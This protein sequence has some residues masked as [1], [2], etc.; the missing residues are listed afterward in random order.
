MKSKLIIAT[1][2]LTSMSQVKAQDATS[3]ILDGMASVGGWAI[4]KAISP[5]SSTAPIIGATV[6][7]MLT[8]WGYGAFKSKDEEEKLKHYIAGRNYERW[9][10][11]QTTWYQSTLDP[12]TGRPPA[13]DGLKTMDDGIPT[14][15]TT[16]ADTESIKKTYTVPVK[17]PAGT[18]GGIPMTERIENFPKLP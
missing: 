8:N 6:A 11:S 3:V 5:K 16:N 7:P 12:T 15:K 4:G 9:I 14:Q 13:F 1:A 2:I 17:M 18:Y 10:K